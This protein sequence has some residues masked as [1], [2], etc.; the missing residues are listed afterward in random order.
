MIR[1]VINLSPIPGILLRLQFPVGKKNKKVKAG[2]RWEN[3]ISRPVAG[4][5]LIMAVSRIIFDKYADSEG[6]IT[7][8][9]FG[10][11]SYNLGHFLEGEALEAAWVSLDSNGNG[12]VS[13]DEFFR[14][15]KS[16]ISLFIWLELMW[17]IDW[18]KKDDRWG[19]LQLSDEQLE[20]LAQVHEIF[21]GYDADDSGKLEKNEFQECY[22]G[23]VN[24][25]FQLTE[26]ET[27][28]DQLD[29]EKNGV[30][31]YNEFVRWLV[32]ENVLT[33]HG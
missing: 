28:F 6:N 16:K 5:F 20:L 19:Y 32:N 26:F 15:L 24:G 30:I 8:E 17:N 23:L 10:S 3:G 29:T 25:G 2:K 1:W 4:F 22:L 18:W 14:K 13:F 31:D 12:T 27:A 33:L 7:K 21:R 11:I 9:Q